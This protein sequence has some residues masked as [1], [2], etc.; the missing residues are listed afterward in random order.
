M[1]PI[2]QSYIGVKMN[3]IVTTHGK[4]AEGILDSLSMFYPISNKIY[5]VSLEENGID[6]F[7]HEMTRIVNQIEGDILILADLFGGTP[8]NIAY[9]LQLL[10]P[11]RIGI[12]AGLN[13]PMLIE[14]VSVIDDAKS[15]SEITDVAYNAGSLGLSKVIGQT[16]DFENEEE[17]DDLF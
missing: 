11:D 10:N 3:I 12:V 4:F 16:K 5:S 17:E 9:E 13:L 14:A 15:L 1:Y 2:R 7:R 6:N 8:Y